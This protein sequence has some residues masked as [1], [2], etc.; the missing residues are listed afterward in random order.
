MITPR[1]SVTQAPSSE[2]IVTNLSSRDQWLMTDLLRARP[3]AE[4]MR[5]AMALARAFRKLPHP[6]CEIKVV[7]IMAWTTYSQSD[8]ERGLKWLRDNGFVRGKRGGRH[9]AVNYTLI[10]PTVIPV[11]LLTGMNAMSQ[12]SIPVRKGLHTRQHADGS[13]RSEKKEYVDTPVSS[14]RTSGAVR[15][16]TVAARESIPARAAAFNGRSA[17]VG[18]PELDEVDWFDGYTPPSRTMVTAASS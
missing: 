8:A 9:D 18:A 13:K 7:T 15:A 17:P 3:P 11:T 16:T 14:T 12:T 10:S 4:A 6:H 1:P 2:I 5:V